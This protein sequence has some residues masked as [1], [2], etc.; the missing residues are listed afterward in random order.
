[1]S[2]FSESLCFRRP[3]EDDNP[4]FSAFPFLVTENVNVWTGP[5]SEEFETGHRK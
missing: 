3:Q 1:M 4:A 2:S 5:K